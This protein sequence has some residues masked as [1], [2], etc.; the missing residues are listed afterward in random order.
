MNYAI[1]LENNK[2]VR[3]HQYDET[4]VDVYSVELKDAEILDDLEYARNKANAINFGA[5]DYFTYYPPCKAVSVVEVI[6]SEGKIH[7]LEEVK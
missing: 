3:L 1:K 2:Y 5:D 7:E 6:I 4:E